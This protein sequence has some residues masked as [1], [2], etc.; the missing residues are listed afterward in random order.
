M[1]RGVAG[2]LRFSVAPHPPQAVAE[3]MIDVLMRSS[4]RPARC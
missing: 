4:D 2:E 1:L 3:D